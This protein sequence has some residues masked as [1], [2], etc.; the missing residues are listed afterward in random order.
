MEIKEIEDKEIWEDFLSLCRDKTFLQSWNWVS[1]IKQ[2][3]IKYGGL[4]LKMSRAF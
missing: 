2:W 1:L 3:G 4:A